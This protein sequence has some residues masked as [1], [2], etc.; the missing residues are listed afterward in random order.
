MV[1]VVLEPDRRDD[2]M[3]A[4][5]ERLGVVRNRVVAAGWEACVI[6]SEK[7]VVLGLL[8]AK[9]LLADPDLPVARV[10]RRGPSTF[11][12]FVSLMRKTPTGRH[13]ASSPV[14]TSDGQLVG[15]VRREDVGAD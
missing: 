12:P 6:V 14:T 4:L 13:M 15:V 5:G 8:R 11:R 1:C 9:E 3:C 2:P 10:M 7:R